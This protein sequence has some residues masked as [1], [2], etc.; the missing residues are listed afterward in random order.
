M[1]KTLT[2]QHERVDDMP[3]LI[4]LANQRRLAEIL[5]RHLGT[6]GRQEGLHHGQLA[7]GWLADI[8]SQ[9]DH[10][11]S[12]VRAW[13]NAMPH[14]RGQLLGQPSRQVEFR[15]DRVG[16][17][18]S[19][20]SDEKAWE[21]M[22][23]ALWAVTV[24]GDE[25]EL[26]GIRL[27][28]TTTYGDHDVTEEGLRQCGPRK[29]HRPDLPPLTLRAAAAEP[30]GHLLAGDG[31][32]GPWADDPL[33]TL[34]IRR[35][36]RIVGRTG[37]LEAGDGKMAALTTRAESAGHGDDSVRP[38]PRTGETATPFARGVEALGEGP[39]EATVLGDGERLRGAGDEVERPR[40]AP[41]D[42][43]PVPW[44]ARV[45]VVR[46]RDWAQRQ[47]GTLDKRLAA[48]EA[49][50]WALTPAPGR[51]Q[52]QIREEATLQAVI[53]SV[54]ARHA[55]AGLLTGASGRHET[56]MPRD[57]G[58]GRGGPGRPT[59]TDVQGR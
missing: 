53:A 57:G 35:V 21:A 8:L 22:E 25:R 26:T 16:G 36:R 6:H 52:R 56:T 38:L 1:A 5:D 48:A 43:P 24:A 29:A 23:Q 30:S 44:T 19:R 14:T 34:R 15:A 59:R 9:A 12:A 20:L 49:E 10:R 4:G 33:Y 18:L 2:L 27:D 32:P 58:R 42:G 37:L 3:L 45:Q 31:K 7:V 40:R 17:V 39:P 28:S 13:A 50:V 55:V 54:L 46:S 51:G 47:Q 41:V 11:Q